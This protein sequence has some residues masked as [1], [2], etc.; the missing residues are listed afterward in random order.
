[1]KERQRQREIANRQA[2]I[3]AADFVQLHEFICS[4]DYVFRAISATEGGAWRVLNAERPGMLADYCG[5][6]SV[7]RG[8]IG[9]QS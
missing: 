6:R 3:D 5:F 7:H 4:D 8:W 2:E 9:G 1:M